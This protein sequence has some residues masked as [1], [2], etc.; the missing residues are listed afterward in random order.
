MA[1]SRLILDSGG[2]SAL[3]E[4]EPRALAWALLATE[5]E[6][7]LGIP[8][9]VLAE[10]LTGQPRDAK[11]YRA[12]PSPDLILDTTGEIAKD[13]SALRYAA[14]Q[15]E[16]TIDAL[17]VATAVRYPHS[18]LLTSDP[19]DLRLLASYRSASALNIRSVNSLPRKT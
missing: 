5:R 2:L 3:A 12:I 19:D 6:M 11:I 1:D 16:K 7:L 18:I 9:P 13:A 10:T 4:G 14:K 8:A 17:V 15:P